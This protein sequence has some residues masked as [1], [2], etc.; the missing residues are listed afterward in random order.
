MQVL[1]HLNAKK[2]PQNQLSLSHGNF[3]RSQNCS[4]SFPGMRTVS[5]TRGRPAVSH[6]R[7][8]VLESATKR[9]D[10]K[11]HVGALHCGLI[12]VGVREEKRG[13]K[14]TTSLLF[15]FLSFFPLTR[16]S[17]VLTVLSDCN[18]KSVRLATFGEL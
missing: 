14:I 10:G 11:P 5:W 13:K 15:L 8:Q 17:R 4:I 3:S 1:T 9:R 12:M 16:P 2:K 18:A 7:S 6:A